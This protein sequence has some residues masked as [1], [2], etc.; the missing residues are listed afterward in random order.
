LT[1]LYQDKKRDV[2]NKSLNEK[3]D[4]TNDIHEKQIIIK[5]YYEQLYSNKLD[6]PEDKTL[7]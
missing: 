2:S 6:N 7:Q 4:I 3:G 1:H 5:D